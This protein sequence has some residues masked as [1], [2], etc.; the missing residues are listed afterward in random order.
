MGDKAKPE[1][2][3]QRIRVRARTLGVRLTEHRD[4]GDVAGVRSELSAVLANLGAIPTQLTYGDDDAKFTASLTGK[5]TG[6]GDARQGQ[7]RGRGLT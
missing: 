3:E 6:D 1:E 2:V 5:V 4:A 7:G